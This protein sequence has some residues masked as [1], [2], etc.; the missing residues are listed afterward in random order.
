MNLR[1][2]RVTGWSAILT[3]MGGSIRILPA[4]SRQLSKSEIVD[5]VGSLWWRR[6][7]NRL[8][9]RGTLLNFTNYIINKSRDCISSITRLDIQGHPNL[10]SHN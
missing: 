4:M 10:D 7:E 3:S 2:R 1:V 5:K 9:A 8:V 6:L